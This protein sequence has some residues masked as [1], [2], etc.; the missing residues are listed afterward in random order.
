MSSPTISTRE[1]SETPPRPSISQNEPSYIR[2]HSRSAC[3]ESTTKDQVMKKVA[4]VALAAGL[5]GK[6]VI[7]FKTGV[8]FGVIAGGISYRNY[9]PEAFAPLE[10]KVRQWVSDVRAYIEKTY[11]GNEKTM[12]MLENYFKNIG[13]KAYELGRAIFSPESSRPLNRV[14]D[15]VEGAVR[16]GIDALH[17]LSRPT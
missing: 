5:F 9:Y 7:G 1:Y 16:A 6:V 3:V 15:S 14:S 10:T 13:D 11:P 8:I 2:S 4:L 12:I 17:S